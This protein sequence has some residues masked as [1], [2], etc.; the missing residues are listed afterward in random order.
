MLK[1]THSQ[2]CMCVRAS[3][4]TDTLTHPT[5]MDVNAHLPALQRAVIDGRVQDVRLLL[6]SGVNIDER[7]EGGG[8]VLH[9][10]ASRGRSELVQILLEHGADVNAKT[11]RGNSA[12]HLACS[13]KRMAN[14]KAIIR[15][16]ILHGA[17]VG[18]QNNVNVQNNA[19]D[20]LIDD[21]AG[22]STPLHFA[23]SESNIESIKLLLA[24]G[25]DISIKEGEGYSSL[26][27]AVQIH[28]SVFIRE[29]NRLHLNPLLPEKRGG[30]DK[31]VKVVQML[32]SHGTDVYAKIARLKA[33]TNASWMVTLTQKTP[34]QVA[35]TDDMKEI[36]RA[37]L[38]HAEESRR[39]MLEAFTM[40][41]HVRL[42][43]ASHI[44]PLAPEVLQMI[45]DRV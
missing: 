28:T 22:G 15:Q 12:L 24:H 4:T 14:R 45:M 43:A 11:N 8:H 17:D 37:A 18:A 10:A 33:L 2:L 5:R 25:A 3:E 32:L 9:V 41:Q 38:I 16:L 7:N 29:R 31:A 36:L 1:P 40:G 13:G 44:L 19:D 39:A 23:V 27:W 42:G 21:F 34:E 30:I 6:A 20:L 35:Y 26:H